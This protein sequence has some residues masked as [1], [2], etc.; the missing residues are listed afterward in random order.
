MGTVGIHGQPTDLGQPYHEGIDIFRRSQGAGE[1]T[2]RVKGQSGKQVPGFQLLD[3]KGCS[4]NPA[5]HLTSVV[6]GTSKG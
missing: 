6:V 3:F 5:Q 1:T 2:I 4:V